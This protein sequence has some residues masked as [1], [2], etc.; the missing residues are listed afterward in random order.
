LI[1]AKRHGSSMI[2]TLYSSDVINNKLRKVPKAPSQIPKE[3][4]VER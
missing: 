1:R 4:N 2:V 3:I